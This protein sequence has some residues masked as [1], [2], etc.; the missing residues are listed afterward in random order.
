MPLPVILAGWVIVTATGT[1]TISGGMGVSKMRRAKRTVTEAENEFELSVAVTAEARVSCETAFEH[2]AA[3]RFQ[4]MQDA[5]VPFTRAFEQLKHVDLIVDVRE[6][7]AP[8]LD[9]VEIIAAGNLSVTAIHVILGLATAAAAG[10]VASTATSAAV[11]AAAAAGTGTAISSLSGV[12]ATNA[13]LAWLGGGPLAA[14]GGGMALGATMAT[15]IA[16]APAV[17]VGGIFLNQKGRAAVAKA[18][19]FA[20]DAE[21][22]LAKH[23]ECQA[24]LAAVTAEG[25]RADELLGH[26]VRRLLPLNGWLEGLTERET[27]W[28]R[29]TDS[30]RERVRLAAT[31]A[32]GASNLVHTPIVDANGALTQAI[33]SACE[34]GAGIL[35]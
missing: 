8:P 30:E 5:L 9:A 23:R 2:L 33:R 25:Q 18:E 24:I 14:G 16:A 34:Q 31:L 12:A 4:A 26:I 13:T 17:L 15:G 35:G 19:R 28:R 21:T 20:A 29:L 1:G 32:V 22:A 11:T 10:A 7:G 3:T 27:D 6:D